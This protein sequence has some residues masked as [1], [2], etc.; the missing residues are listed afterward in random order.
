[1][2]RRAANQSNDGV[3]PATTAVGAAG[4][5]NRRKEFLGA[6]VEEL[7]GRIK[8]HADGDAHP[9]SPDR[10]RPRRSTLGGWGE[11]FRCRTND[12]STK[13]AE[14]ADYVEHNDY[15]KGSNYQ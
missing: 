4:R 11:H 3:Q 9:I 12:P 6:K 10:L 13:H 5:T 15:A 7:T 1:M 14:K 2:K 8:S